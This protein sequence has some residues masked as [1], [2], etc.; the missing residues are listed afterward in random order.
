MLLTGYASPH[1]IRRIGHTRLAAWLRQRKVRDSAGVAARAITAARAQM[2]V[3]PGQ[4]LAT[5][6]IAELATNILAL[7]ERLGRL[8]AQIAEAFGRHPPGRGHRIDARLRPA[9]R[10]IVAR[11]RR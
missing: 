1:Q 7:D 10:C 4:D 6:L 8:D 2:T 5:S 9:S 3:L 11:R